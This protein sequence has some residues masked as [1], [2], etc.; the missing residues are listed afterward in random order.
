MKL[1]DDFNLCNEA[2]QLSAASLK[3]MAE[4]KPDAPTAILYKMLT[5]VNLPCSHAFFYPATLKGDK[6]RRVT[7]P[8]A[9]LTCQHYY[10]LDITCPSMEINTVADSS[11]RNDI[12]ALY[13]DLPGDECTTSSGAR[14]KVID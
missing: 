14:Y 2:F 13:N 9:C 8:I 7:F 10:L 4:L 1:P 11:N 12:V 6:K 5:E 3:M